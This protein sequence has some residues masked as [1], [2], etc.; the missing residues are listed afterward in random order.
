MPLT[1]SKFP[2]KFVAA[3]AFKPMRLKC[4]EVRGS[5]LHSVGPRVPG[6]VSGP[7]QLSGNSH[8]THPEASPLSGFPVGNPCGADILELGVER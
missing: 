7:G 5:V 8:F 2:G 3:L 6:I 4:Q 1:G